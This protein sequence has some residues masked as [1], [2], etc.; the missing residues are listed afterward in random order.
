MIPLVP[1]ACCSERVLGLI[2]SVLMSIVQC[3]VNIIEVLGTVFAT[4][5]EMVH[6]HT[7]NE[8]MRY[9]RFGLWMCNSRPRKQF[10][11]LLPHYL[12]TTFRP[13][14]AI[15]WWYNVFVIL[16]GMYGYLCVFILICMLP[17]KCC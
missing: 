16:N 3:D 2:V 9:K 8:I 17:S 14:R 4:C 13:F 11:S 15:I 5:T 10:W 6:E 7:A 1:L 12:T